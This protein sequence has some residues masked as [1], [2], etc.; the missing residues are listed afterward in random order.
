MAQSRRD[1]DF[2]ARWAE[3]LARGAAYDRAVSRRLAI[4]VPVAIGVAV[5]VC[6]FRIR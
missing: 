2:D 3:W 6:V 1:P 4:P 5:F